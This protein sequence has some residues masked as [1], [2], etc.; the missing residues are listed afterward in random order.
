VRFSFSLVGRKAKG[1]MAADCAEE[2]KANAM[3]IFREEGGSDYHIKW[4]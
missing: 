1:K 4:G 2:E 3:K